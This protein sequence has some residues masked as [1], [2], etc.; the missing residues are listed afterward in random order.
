[1]QGKSKSILDIR[2]RVGVAGLGGV[3][4][5]V[6][7]AGVVG[8]PSGLLLGGLAGLEGVHLAGDGVYNNISVSI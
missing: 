7:L 5:G 1:M 2:F 3:A 4:V 8:I 6:T